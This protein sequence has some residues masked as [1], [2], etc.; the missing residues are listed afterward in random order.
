MSVEGSSPLYRARLAVLLGLMVAAACAR[1]VPHPPNVTPVAAMALLGGATFV[2]RRAA[3]AVPLGAMLLSDIGLGL[4]RY[5]PSL[6]FTPML[7]VIYGCFVVI[8]CLGFLLRGRR[9]PLRVAM[10]TLTASV[11]FFAVTNLG[12]W[13][14]GDLYPRTG[15]GLASCFV[16]A[17]PF[18]RN[19]LAGDAVSAFA[20]F[21]ALGMIEREFPRL[22]DP[23]ACGPRRG[24]VRT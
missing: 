15:A 2:D 10:V 24:A 4:L 21:G 7:L 17:I 13:A 16:E 11:L 23:I 20:L 5:H 22:A 9:S 19:T 12:V 1:L 6:V 8:V 18:F 3:L 14:L